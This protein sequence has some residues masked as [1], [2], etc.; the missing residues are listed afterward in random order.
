MGG[1]LRILV[2]LLAV[3]VAGCSRNKGVKPKLISFR[4][5]NEQAAKGQPRSVG[6]V[7]MVNGAGRFVVIESGPWGAPEKDA[8]LKCFREGKEIGVVV[9]SVERRGRLLT[10]DIVT[11]DIA[12]G[13]E[14]FQ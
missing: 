14:V 8:P 12:R 7:V 9:M 1:M 3:S 5:A 6:K 10:A 13:D 2:V 4:Y 11:G